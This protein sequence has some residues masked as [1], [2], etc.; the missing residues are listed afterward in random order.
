MNIFGKQLYGKSQLSDIERF[1]SIK[2]GH[3]KMYRYYIM[4]ISSSKEYINW[5]P[6]MIYFVA[7]IF[8]NRFV[9]YFPYCEIQF[10]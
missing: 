2:H 1:L 8:N 4:Q 10:L 3:T 7:I 9:W 5:I 6:S